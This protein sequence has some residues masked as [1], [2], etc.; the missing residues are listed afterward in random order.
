[1]LGEIVHIKS[2]WSGFSRR[3]DWQTRQVGLDSVGE[4]S[5]HSLAY[6]TA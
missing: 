3:W 5:S 6:Q 4:A 1:V 2:S